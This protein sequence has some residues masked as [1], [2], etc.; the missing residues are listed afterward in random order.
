MYKM[1]GESAKELRITKEM[2][3]KWEDDHGVVAA[4]D[5]AA[6]KLKSI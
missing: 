3:T 5:A 6:E 2:F 4:V 1:L